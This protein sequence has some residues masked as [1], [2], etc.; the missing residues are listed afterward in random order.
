MTSADF[1]TYHGR[2]T[3]ITIGVVMQRFFS[4]ALAATLVS[5]TGSGPAFTMEEGVVVEHGTR[6]F[7]GLIE[8]PD[9]FVAPADGF[10]VGALLAAANGAPPVICSL[11]AQAVRNGSWGGGSDIPSSALPV[12]ELPR[13]SRRHRD[14]D[15]DDET[16]SKELTAA[17][18][19]QLLQALGSSDPCVRELSVRLI[20]IADDSLVAPGLVSR[21]KS[22]NAPLRALAAVGLGLVDAEGSADQLIGVLRDADTAVR[23]NAA[24]ALGRMESG[25][26]LGALTG[27]FGDKSEPVR[28]AA[29]TAVGHMDS[30]SAT[31]SLIRVV[32]SDES[33]RV[34]RVA[35]WALGELDAHD[36]I[37]ALGSVLAS[38]RDANV[39][40]MAA[41]ALGEISDHAG[42]TA[43]A[44]AARRDADD[45][46][47]EMA[48]WALAE[49][50]DG[51]SAEVLGQV[52][53]SDKSSRVRGTAAWGI[54]QL[55]DDNGHAPA[56]LI[57]AL[58]DASADTRL[59]AAWALGQIGDS[60]ALPAIRDALKQ[61]QSAGVSRALIRALM[62]S[63]ERS[64]STLNE[65]LN[66]K[67]PRVR[68]VAVRGLAGNNRF[69][70]WPWPMPRPRP[71]P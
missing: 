30:T 24:W 42:T 27:L 54:G 17:D 34:R 52:A 47:R 4:F 48:V 31:T 70:P 16:P 12:V 51:S 59:K 32:K 46:V 23:A 55:D 13:H 37:E 7:D 25:R 62:K 5:M 67:D 19:Q 50:G 33:A 29:V 69:N 44:T 58:K 8:Q 56:G 38:D 1:S 11:A 6:A 64:E 71:F 2:L 61:E 15:D 60:A 66:S 57:Q 65:L 3:A 63:G 41:W 49:I 53:A 21:L 45:D 68:E 20:G 18:V 10:D 35:A 39:R 26:A 9:R 40:E 28:L 43:L 22:D 14:A 36:A